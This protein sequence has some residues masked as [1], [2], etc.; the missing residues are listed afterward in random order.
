MYLT[1]K[2]VQRKSRVKS[3]V[4]RNAKIIDATWSM[5]S[6]GVVTV[7]PAWRLEGELFGLH[8]KELP[9]VKKNRKI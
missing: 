8:K 1:V 5:S 9:H 3:S 7:H 4:L 2:E 6:N